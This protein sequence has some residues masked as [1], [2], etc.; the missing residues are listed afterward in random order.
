[1]QCRLSS[2]LLRFV[3]LL[4]SL[5]FIS[6]N[7]YAQETKLVPRSPITREIKSD[8]KH[9]YQLNANAGEFIHIVIRQRGINVFTVLFD[10][11]G[12]ERL[13]ADSP[14]SRSETEWL[15]WKSETSSTYKI[16]VRG[17]VNALYG[18]S[19]KYEIEIIEQRPFTESDQQ[20]IMAQEVFLKGMKSSEDKD[21]PQSIENFQTALAQYQQANRKSE[22]AVCMSSIGRGFQI[23]NKFQEA[24]EW[25]GKALNAYREAQDENAEMVMHNQLGVCYTAA[26]QY[27]KAGEEFS[28]TLSLSQKLGETPNLF[29]SVE[30]LTLAACD[31]ATTSNGK[32]VEG[33]AYMAQAAGAKNVIASLLP[34]EDN[35]AAELMRE[36]YRGLS[37]SSRDSVS[38]SFRRAALKL[39]QSKRTEHPFYWASLV[40]VGD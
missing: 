1:M 19:G 30:L 20:R 33:L 27:S 39:L 24:I 10:A 12:K 36:F 8:E 38:I 6:T 29:G 31:T 7:L 2:G 26:N 22:A 32:E 34:L 3:V 35:S 28:Q 11:N 4:C 18:K 16:E 40:V 25:Y 15:N 13:K 5:V 9:S 37:L 23:Q 14:F 17:F 21:Y